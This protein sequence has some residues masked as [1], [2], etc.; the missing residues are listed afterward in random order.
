MLSLAAYKY[1]VSFFYLLKFPSVSFISI[2]LFLGYRSGGFC[3]IYTCLILWSDCK[4]HYISVLLLHAVNRQ[5]CDWSWYMPLIFR[6]TSRLGMCV[7][8]VVVCYT[9]LRSFLETCFFCDFSID[10]TMFPENRGHF[11]SS[12]Q[13]CLS[14]LFLTLWKGLVRLGHSAHLSRKSCYPGFSMYLWPSVVWL[15]G[16]TLVCFVCR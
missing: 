3:Y 13:T 1:R 10:V 6:N 5:K 4:Q 15:C 16:V 12:F 9:S 14:F 8:D 2:W 7:F 11:I